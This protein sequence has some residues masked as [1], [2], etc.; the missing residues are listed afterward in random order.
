MWHSAM[1]LIET[2]ESEPLLVMTMGQ[3]TE[4]CTN[5]TP[6]MSVHCVL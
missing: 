3:K 5:P 6:S 2:S 1:K 4:G